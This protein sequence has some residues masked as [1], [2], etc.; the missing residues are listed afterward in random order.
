MQRFER[1][2]WILDRAYNED[3]GASGEEALG[4]GDRDAIESYC[5]AN[6]IEFA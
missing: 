6:A 3:F 1:E 5:R 4:T 2:G